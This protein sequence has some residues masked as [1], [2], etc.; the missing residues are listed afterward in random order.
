MV[1]IPVQIKIPRDLTTTESRV[2]YRR[3]VI[4]WCQENTKS[5][6]KVLWPHLEYGSTQFTIEAAFENAKE[7]MLFK[8]KW[9]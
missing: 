2:Y 1:G 5:K 8:L 6:Y 3:D 9:A 7:A 4:A